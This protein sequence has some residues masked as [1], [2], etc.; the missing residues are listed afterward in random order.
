MLDRNRRPCRIHICSLSPLF[1]ESFF[2][3]IC[4]KGY[5][6]ISYIRGLVYKRNIL[7]V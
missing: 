3:Q 7:G 2:L 1:F 4:Y 5:R 6:V